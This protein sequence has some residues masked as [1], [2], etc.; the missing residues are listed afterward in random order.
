MS[1]LARLMESSSGLQSSGQE[2]PKK[3]GFG[4]LF[5][6]GTEVLKKGASGDAAPGAKRS[7]SQSGPT[8]GAKSSGTAVLKKPAF[9]S[10][11]SL[12]GGKSDDDASSASKRSGSQSVRRAAAAQ[13]TDRKQ[14]QV[15]SPCVV[16]RHAHK[17]PSF[18]G[19]ISLIQLPCR[20]PH[21]SIPYLDFQ[22]LDVDCQ[23]Q[24][25]ATHMGPEAV[26]ELL[27]SPDM[28]RWRRWRRNNVAPVPKF[29]RRLLP[30][31][32]TA[33]PTIEGS[34]NYDV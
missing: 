32:Q 11:V 2:A 19:L 28:R 30:S 29:S 23:H 1:P 22:A 16:D 10:L 13:G 3:G 21:V 15:C 18:W 12:F 31:C 20:V 25:V 24:V 7:G 8:R 17:I 4:G 6:G 27:R 9:G 14:A 26:T 34:T 5:G 33:L